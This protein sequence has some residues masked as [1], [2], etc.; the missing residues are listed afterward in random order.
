MFNL[1]QET[2]EELIKMLEKSVARTEVL[3]PDS[4]HKSKFV[5]DVMEEMEEASEARPWLMCLTLLFFKAMVY[6]HERHRNPNGNVKSEMRYEERRLALTFAAK[7]GRMASSSERTWCLDDV[8]NANRMSP[9]DVPFLIWSGTLQF[10]S[11]EIVFGHWDWMS[12]VFKML[13]VYLLVLAATTASLCCQTPPH[14]KMFTI[15]VAL[16]GAIF[17]FNFYK[18]ITFA[19]FKIGSRYFKAKGLWTCVLRAQDD[20]R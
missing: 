8:A 5:A 14:T 2:Q 10:Q 4:N 11:K 9:F 16:A 1:D 17:L 15:M 18:S 3:S 20:D 7:Y 19:V 12:G 6:F 13:P